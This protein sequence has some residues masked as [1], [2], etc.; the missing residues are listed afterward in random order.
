[1]FDRSS[2]NVFDLDRRKFL[3]LVVHLLLSIA[4][5]VLSRQVDQQIVLLSRI[6]QLLD[7]LFTLHIDTIKSQQAINT[8]IQ[9][10]VT[11]KSIKSHTHTHT[12]DHLLFI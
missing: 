9:L 7:K 6:T 4:F 5:V 10:R 2:S 11:R 12:H 8:I 3:P 1:M